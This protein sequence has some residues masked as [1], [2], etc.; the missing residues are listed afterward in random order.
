MKKTNVLILGAGGQ[1][2]KHVIEFLQEKE[3]IHL[4]LFLRNAQQIKTTKG[5][6]INIIEG[7][8]L[9]K[10]ELDAAVK[11][12][13][14]VYANLAG[15]VDKM[16]KQVVD[17]MEANGVK[18]LIFVTSLGIYNEVPGAFGKWNN[19]MIGSSLV[20][21]RKAADKIET[22]N[23]DYTIVRPAWL[24]DNDEVDYELTQKGEVFKGTEVSRKSVASF[25]ADI[26]VHPEREVK[27]SVGV[28]KPGTEGGKPAFY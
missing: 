12:Q 1:I 28:D 7:D 6:A 22:S 16:A 14:I 17:A 4:T 3:N 15:N 5:S 26:I 20:T 18:R 8:V 2:A 21:Y 13:G 11:G 23:L 9:N 25:I 19:K 10:N 24:T 27:A